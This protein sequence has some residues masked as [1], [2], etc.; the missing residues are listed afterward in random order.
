MTVTLFT[1]LK[2]CD[3][4]TSEST[5]E[6]ANTHCTQSTLELARLCHLHRNSIGSEIMNGLWTQPATIS[7]YPLLEQLDQLSCSQEV[8]ELCAFH[9]VISRRWPFAMGDSDAKAARTMSEF[10][11]KLAH[12]KC[13]AVAILERVIGGVLTRMLRVECATIPYRK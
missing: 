13:L 5:L 9:R 3:Q 2:Q 7:I 10:V 6:E 11:E 4:G 1:A 12:G 8:K